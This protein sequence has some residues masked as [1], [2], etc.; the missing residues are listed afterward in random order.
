MAEIHAVHTNDKSQRNK[1]GGDDGEYTHD[2]V[3]AVAGGRDININ[4]TGGHLTV[5]F[6]QVQNLNG[7]VITVTQI[8]RGTFFDEG[9]ISFAINY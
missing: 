4:Q 9:I 3:E 7:V 5:V 6:Y 1:D 2:F 8:D